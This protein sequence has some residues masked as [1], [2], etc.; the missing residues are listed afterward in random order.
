MNGKLGCR[1]LILLTLAVLWGCSLRGTGREVEQ[2][3]S[4]RQVG[5]VRREVKALEDAW[6]RGDV[7]GAIRQYAPSVYVRVN[8]ERWEYAKEVA[9]IEEGMKKEPR[10]RLRIDVNVILPLGRD[11]A[12]VDGSFHMIS[13]DGSDSGGP[14]TALEEL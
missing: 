11:Y 2:G 9:S 3:E 14:F 1:S 4:S 13:R 5:E 12:L 7:A 10:P 6:N 8:S